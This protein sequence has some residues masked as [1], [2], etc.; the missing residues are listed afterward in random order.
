MTAREIS[1]RAQLF[2]QPLSQTND[3]QVL[4]FQEFCRLNRI[5]E[6]TGRRLIHSPNGPA[7]VKLTARRYGVTIGANK[8]W[9]AA[10]TQRGV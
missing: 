1:K 5:S 4:T 2:A 8:A 7:F 6:K 10:R 9:Q 3:D